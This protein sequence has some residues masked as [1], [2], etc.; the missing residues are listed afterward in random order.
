M[1]IGRKRTPWFGVGLVLLLVGCMGGGDGDADGEGGE[2]TVTF[3]VPSSPTEAA[4][5]YE[6]AMEDLL[7]IAQEVDDPD[8]ARELADDFRMKAQELEAIADSFEGENAM[9]AGAAL[10]ARAQ[11]IAVLGQQLAQEVARISTDANLREPFS[12][13]IAAFSESNR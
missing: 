5:S 3:Q 9:A 2:G 6:A 4:E 10:A 1:S 11:T 7:K 13:A 12:E 8:S